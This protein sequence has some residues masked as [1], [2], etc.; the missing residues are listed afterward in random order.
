[1]R[2]Y[3]YRRRRFFFIP[4]ILAAIAAFT[5]VTML[6]WNELMPLLFHLPT[7]TFW[8][9]LGLL[10]L[11]RLFFGGGWHGGWFGRGHWQRHSF[12][13]KMSKMSSEEREEFIK[14]MRS[15]HHAWHQRFGEEEG[16]EEGDQAE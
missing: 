7:I 14:K 12:F 13:D 15:R 10:I 8:Q 11:G 9:A 16:R 5:A 6:L 1:M 4:L 3:G 2:T